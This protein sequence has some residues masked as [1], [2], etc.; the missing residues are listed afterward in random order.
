MGN[1][2]SNKQKKEFLENNNNKYKF[3]LTRNYISDISIFY[4]YEKKYESISNENIILNKL[5]NSY[6]FLICGLIDGFIEIYNCN[7]KDEFILSLSFKAHREMIS[8][9]LQLKKG[10]YLL[11]GSIDNSFKI[12]KLSHNFTR[13]TLIYTIYLQTIFNRINDIIQINNGENLLLSVFN[14]IIFFPY[15]QNN[16]SDTKNYLRDYTYSKFEH[17]NIFLSDLLEINEQLFLSLDEVGYKILFFTII[18]DKGNSKNIKFIKNILIGSKEENGKKDIRSKICIENLF[19]KYNFIILSINSSI[20]IIDIKYL[21]II[22]IYELKKPSFFLSYSNIIERIIIIENKT[23]YKYKIIYGKNGLYFLEE[24]NE[25]YEI[26]N[27]I[28]LIKIRKV[29]YH[30][31]R[32]NILYLF[33]KKMLMKIELNIC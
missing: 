13:E 26:N 33:Y 19:P 14:H 11:T 30:P 9:I 6:I 5:N 3:I 29:V 28:E 16:L 22:F 20:K 25:S 24:N 7:I 8:K 21:E 4:N 32:N 1:N 31:L 10:G 12:F 2:N 17:R 27:I 23:L 15:T 18:S